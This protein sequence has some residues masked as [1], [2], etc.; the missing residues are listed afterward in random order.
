MPVRSSARYVAPLA[1]VAFLIVLV[2]VV[3]SSGGGH[4]SSA[5]KSR[6]AVTSTAKAAPRP[7]RPRKYYVIKSNDL[8]ST[9]ASKTGVS[10]E[11]I[12]QLNPDLDPQGLVPGERIKL[13]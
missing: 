2:I 3:S 8:L 13:R 10:T 12:Q 5:S 1:L 4:S 7:R 11:R 6:P 9:I